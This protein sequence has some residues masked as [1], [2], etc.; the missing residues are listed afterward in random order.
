M[1]LKRF[2]LQ[3]EPPGVGLEVEANGSLDIRHKDLPSASEMTSFEDVSTVVDGLIEQEPDIL[4]RR[5]HRQALLQLLG[6]LYQ[7]VIPNLEADMKAHQKA[8]KDADNNHAQ[9]HGGIAPVSKEP[10]DNY[11]LE[12]GSQVCMIGLKGAQQIH[13]GELGTLTKA[14]SGKD[15]Y[16]VLLQ[17]ARGTTDASETLKVRGAEHLVPVL[18]VTPLAVGMHVAIRGLRN[19]VEL[20]GCLG[21]VVECHVESHRFEVRATESGQLFRV[22]Q[23]NLVPLGPCPQVLAA[24]ANAKEPPVASSKVSG[25]ASSSAAAGTEQHGPVTGAEQHGPV[26]GNGEDEPI[27]PGSVVQLA[28]LKS[29]MGYNGQTAEVLSVDKMRGR[30]EIRLGDGSVKTIRAENVRLMS[31]PSKASP[32]QR[33]QKDASHSAGKPAD[34]K[35]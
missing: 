33:R 19:H 12:E 25:S 2:L 21:R 13:N 24:A 14:N 20:N 16:E 32:R 31:G 11:A 9:E 18:K 8:H 17:P 28:G 29:A 1:K 5:R 3:Y 6:R 30:Y 34:R 27:E 35:H 15:K 22:K 7:E 10:A 26:S 4:S 23:E